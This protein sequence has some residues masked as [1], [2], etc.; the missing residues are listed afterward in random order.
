MDRQV[1]ADERKESVNVRNEGCRLRYGQV[2]C[3]EAME[4][5]ALLALE[6]G[7]CA[8]GRGEVEEGKWAFECHR[9]RSDD[10]G[11]LGSECLIDSVVQYELE[12]ELGLGNARS[13][14]NGFPE[15]SAKRSKNLFA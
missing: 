10:R 2:W 14:S 15:N 9:G 1:A 11:V 8:E 3:I 12:L 5:S 4:V 7:G 6:M 13:C